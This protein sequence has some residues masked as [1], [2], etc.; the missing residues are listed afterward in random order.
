MNVYKSNEKL[1]KIVDHEMHRVTIDESDA[2]LSTVLKSVRK[3]AAILG[4]TLQKEIRQNR[5]MNEDSRDLA[6]VFIAM[7]HNRC[8]RHALEKK[9][10]QA[11]VSRNEAAFL[12]RLYFDGILL[13]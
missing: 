3:I 1:L 6:Q 7:T 12:V 9:G 2:T 8:M 4:G 10:L 5:I 11:M 13:P